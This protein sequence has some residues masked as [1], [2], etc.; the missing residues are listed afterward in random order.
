MRNITTIM[1]TEKKQLKEIYTM[2]CQK[3]IL[4]N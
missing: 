4:N 2:N 3:L 1:K